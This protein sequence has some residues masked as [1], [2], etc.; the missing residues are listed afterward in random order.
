M[1]ASAAY[2]HKLKISDPINVFQER[3]LRVDPSQTKAHQAMQESKPEQILIEESVKEI[4]NSSKRIQ[5]SISFLRRKLGKFLESSI[6]LLQRIVREVIQRFLQ[7]IDLC[8]C[9]QL[10]TFM[11]SQ[12]CLNVIC[13]T[14]CSVGRWRL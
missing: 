4:E 8:L 5:K 7:I 13:M 2:E 6:H 3:V 14:Y 10:D 11:N 9:G 12:F 1:Q